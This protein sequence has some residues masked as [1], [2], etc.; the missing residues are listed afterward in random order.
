[1]VIA[2]EH[3]D[4][5]VGEV[6]GDYNRRVVFPALD[7]LFGIGSRVDEGPAQPIVFLELVDH[8]IARIELA[9]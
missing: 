1:M 6:L 5:I 3:R 4:E 9:H 2:I 7:A 8:L